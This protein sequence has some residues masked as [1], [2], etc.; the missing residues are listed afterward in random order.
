M[1]HAYLIGHISILDAQKW[2]EYKNK[3]PATLEPWN[4]ELVLRGNVTAVFA[5][6]HPQTDTV[7]IRFSDAATLNNW[8]SS[9]AYQALI[10][11]REQAADMNLICAE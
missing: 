11:L 4:A 7:I 1:K 3:V 2:T 10:P 6:Q 5:G 9:A 8:Y